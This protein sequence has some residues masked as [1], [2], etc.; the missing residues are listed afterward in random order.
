MGGE[1]LFT[2]ENGI[3]YDRHTSPSGIESILSVGNETKFSTSETDSQTIYQWQKFNLGTEVYENDTSNTTPILGKT[4][5]N[6]EVVIAVVHEI[7][8]P[9][10][11]EINDNLMV[12]MNGLTDIYMAQ[13]GL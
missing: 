11:Q 13:L 2:I 9:T 1:S 8:Q 6:G 7:I 3:V 10:N 5:V 4:P 12:I